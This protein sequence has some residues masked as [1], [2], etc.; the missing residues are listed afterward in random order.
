MHPNSLY[1]A[2]I[3]AKG[4]G[5]SPT[6][7]ILLQRSDAPINVGEDVAREL[8]VIRYGNVSTLGGAGRE[9]QRKAN[10]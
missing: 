4:V 10:L 2:L 6:I 3:S 1:F 8:D 5:R 7:I 9:I